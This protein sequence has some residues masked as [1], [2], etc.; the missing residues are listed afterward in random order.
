MNNVYRDSFSILNNTSINIQNTVKFEHLSDCIFLHYRGGRNKKYNLNQ[1]S[2]HLHLIWDVNKP[3]KR[4]F[5][6][7]ACVSVTSNHVLLRRSVDL[8]FSLTRRQ[9]WTK[10]NSTDYL[11][12][13]RSQR[14]GFILLK[15]VSNYSEHPS[16]RQ[17]CARKLK[18]NQKHTNNLFK[19]HIICISMHITLKTLAA[20]Y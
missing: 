15:P 4:V 17:R 1:Y 6:L 10:I 5:C 13:S 16:N 12:K 7:S 3:I 2:F 11:G 18:R 14:L 19:L 9:K 8:Q 20:T